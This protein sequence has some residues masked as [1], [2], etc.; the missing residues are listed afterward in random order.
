MHDLQRR[1]PIDFAGPAQFEI[2][3]LQFSYPSGQAALRGIDLSVAAGERIA[4]VGQNGSGK[5]T[6]VKHLNGLL[7]VQQGELIYQGQP[8][9]GEHLQRARLEIGLLFQDPDDQLFCST[10]YDDVSFGPLN[11]GVALAAMEPLVRQSL[12]SVGLEAVIYKASH[13]LSYGQKSV[14][15]W[16]VCWR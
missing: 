9:V 1:P 3:N 11:Q 10:L 16:P 14:L 2:R 5:S 15:R 7:A 4:L 8:L 12:A 13:L 6:L